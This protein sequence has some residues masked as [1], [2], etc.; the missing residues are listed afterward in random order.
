MKLSIDSVQVRPGGGLSA[1]RMSFHRGLIADGLQRR[2]ALV[3][4]SQLTGSPPDTVL[5][6][7]PEAA[8]AWRLLC[9]SRFWSGSGSHVN[10]YMITPN[11]VIEVSVAA[12]GLT[13]VDA[14][15]RVTPE[16]AIP[17]ASEAGGAASLEFF[18][19]TSN[20]DPFQV[21]V[22]WLPSTVIQSGP[23]RIFGV[24]LEHVW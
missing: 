5:N 13:V 3:V 17:Y 14:Q 15:M 12:P 7:S 11:K 23:G 9:Y 10:E 18:F 8:G 16:I 24:R 20:A 4:E 6:V 21:V 19:R 1:N 22:G 2:P